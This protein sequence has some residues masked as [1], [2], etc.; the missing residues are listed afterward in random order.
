MEG[1]GPVMAD[2]EIEPGV[3][4][5]FRNGRAGSEFSFWD[6]SGFHSSRQ[7]GFAFRRI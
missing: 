6:T 4:A 1:H 5:S 3:G 7:M 2:Q